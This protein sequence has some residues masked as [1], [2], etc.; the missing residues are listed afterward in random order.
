M[1]TI[2]SDITGME[3]AIN[4]LIARRRMAK[5]VTAVLLRSSIEEA[6]LSV[7]RLRE[8]KVRHETMQQHL[9]NGFEERFQRELLRAR[10]HAI[11]VRALRD[12]LNVPGAPRSEIE[13]RLKLLE[14]ARIDDPSLNEPFAHLDFDEDTISRGSQPQPRGLPHWFLLSVLLAIVVAL[15]IW[16]R[17]R[18]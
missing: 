14:T 6:S 10:R 3:R 1:K 7:Q 15:V 9:E 11:R 2:D 4:A 16:R 8:R 13:R 17:V 18:S 5:G 12:A